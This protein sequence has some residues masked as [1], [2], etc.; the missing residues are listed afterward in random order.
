VTTVPIPAGSVKI[1]PSPTRDLSI[2]YLRTTLT[3][4]VIAHHS[5]LAYTT[6]AY[7]NKQHM[8]QS[9]APVVDVSRWLFF[10]Y[11]ENFNDVFFMSLMFFVSGLFVYPALRRHGTLSFIR[12]R[13]LRLGLPFAFAVVFL[14]PI[15]YYAS[16]Q[17][18]G[19][20]TGFVD[21]Y[22]RLASGGFAVGPPWFIWL[23]LFF[24]IVLALLLLPFH[25]FIPAAGRFMTR[26]QSHPIATFAAIYLLAALVY[27]PLLVRYGFAAWTSF[28]T[29]PFSF[30]ICRI[31]LYA[32]WFIFGVFVGV[33]GFA[34]GLLSK[35]GSL[36][37][38]RRLW[39]LA[40]VVIYNTLIFVPRLPITHQL[41]S[42]SQ[43]TL[44]A[45]LWVASCVASCFG[46]L[47]LFRGI[48]FKSRAWMNSLS[49]SAYIMYLVHYVFITWT[50]RLVLD[51]PIH[52]A[53]KFLFVFL[54]TTFLSWLTAQLILRIPTLKTIL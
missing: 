22:Q 35:E 9:T 8:F 46:F 3:L 42:S 39:M 26:L 36:A 51:R 37:R 24:D 7:F 5:S 16:W 41:S 17:L 6:F 33:P 25:R 15:A 4:M 11:A 53:F 1:K 2:D 10:D 29:S 20:S 43:G 48:N 13:F 49:R 27:L 50:Q 45:L 47:A 30:Q 23:L 12:D 54:A 18:T 44:E 40:C 52:V 28:I 14:M 34:N 19:R 21:F 31:G 32:L 38:H